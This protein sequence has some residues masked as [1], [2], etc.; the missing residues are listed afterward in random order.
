MRKLMMLFVCLL[1]ASVSSAQD[2]SLLIDGVNKKFARVKDY[3]ADA[4]ID[5]KISFLNGK[6]Y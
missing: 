4:L 3:Q 5:T 6:E 2:A 1:M